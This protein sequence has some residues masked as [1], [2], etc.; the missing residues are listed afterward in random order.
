MEIATIGI[1]LAA[2]WFVHN[3]LSEESEDTRSRRVL[4]G[5]ATIK[6]VRCYSVRR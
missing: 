4:V 2:C 5:Y 3:D 1:A 6:M